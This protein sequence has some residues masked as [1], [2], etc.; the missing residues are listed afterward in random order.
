MVDEPML[1]VDDLHVQFDASD[2]VVRAVDGLSF[3]LGAGESLGLV[4][5]SGCGKS[6]TSLSLL[7]L[8]SPGRITGGRIVWCG[9]DLAAAPED[10]VRQVRGRQV[11]MVF[12]DPVSS[13]DPVMTVGAQ[14]AETFAQL[15]DADR[16]ESRRL[17]VEALQRVGMPD[18]TS[19]ARYYPHQLSGGQCQRVMI[20]AAL[21]GE[22][23][24][25]VADE[26]T[27]ALDATTQARILRLLDR[28]RR[29]K[30]LALLLVSHDLDVVAHLTDR[31]LVMYAGRVAEVAP[32]ASLF[33]GARHPYTLGLLASRPSL[34]GERRSRLTALPGS[35]R[36]LPETGCAFLPRCSEAD[37]RCAVEVPRLLPVGGEHAVACHRIEEA[38]A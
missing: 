19:R 23:R 20:A 11:G 37:E 7:R 26:P 22:P 18:P 24:L 21:A 31:V 36:D 25:L 14:L 38:G 16:K 2:G 9:Q 33:D 1:V 27:T 17:A 30:E 8:E 5:E 35:A 6:V 10:R 12:Q 15:L 28:L 34:T 13:L 3:D 32:T 29:E 4:G